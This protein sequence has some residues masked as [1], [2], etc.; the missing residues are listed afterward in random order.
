MMLARLQ[1][2]PEAAF[3]EISETNRR[4]TEGLKLLSSIKD[5]DVQIA[6]T[7]KVEVLRRDK[8]VLYHYKDEGPL[9][10]DDVHPIFTRGYLATDFFLMLSGF[11]LGR[12]YGAQVLD[13]QLGGLQFWLRR[14]GR[15]WPGRTIPS[16]SACR[17][18]RCTRSCRRLPSRR[19]RMSGSA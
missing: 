2:T 6:T 13:R 4:M 19:G 14:A 1:F 3:R 9:W 18:G 8:T 16:I 7:P 17:A 11:V 5:E 12:V 10:L 15:V